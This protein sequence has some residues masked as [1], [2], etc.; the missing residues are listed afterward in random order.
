MGCALCV[1]VLLVALYA[2]RGRDPASAG[3]PT[4]SASAPPSARPRTAVTRRL[5][6]AELAAE[7]EVAAAVAAAAGRRGGRVKAE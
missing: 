2:L 3:P 1:E 4:L 6:E 7:A 5:T